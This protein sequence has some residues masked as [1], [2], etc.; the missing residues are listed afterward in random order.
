MRFVG[1][2]NIRILVFLRGGPPNLN[3][4]PQAFF[5]SIGPIFGSTHKRIRC[6]FR[7]T[8]GK[9]HI[10]ISKA[11]GSIYIHDILIEGWS[12]SIDSKRVWVWI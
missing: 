5:W 10:P 2:I 7:L 6:V 3:A 9:G 12:K 11:N 1:G 8:M 4:R